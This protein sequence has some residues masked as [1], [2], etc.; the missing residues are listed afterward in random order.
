[1]KGLIV[2]PPVHDFAMPYLAGPLLKGYIEKIDADVRVTCVDLNIEFFKSA[3]EDYPSLLAR[4]R[5][6]LES[7]SLSEAVSAAILYQNQALDELEK[8]S[9]KHQG[10]AWSLRNYK[11][12]LDR[13]VFSE[14]IEYSRSSTPFDELFLTF[15]GQ[16]PTPDFFAVSLTVED[17][18]LPTFR[19]LRLARENWHEI[20]IILGGNLVNRI[21]RFMDHHELSEICDFAVLREGEEPLLYLLRWIRGKGSS[22]EIDP[23]IIDLRSSRIPAMGDLNSIPESLHTKLDPDFQPDFSDLDVHGYLAPMPILPILMSR[24][25]YWGRCSFCT[26]HSAWDPTHRRRRPD[27]ILKELEDSSNKHN[28]KYFRVVD[29]SCPPDL[30]S[31]VSEL[32]HLNSLDIVFEIYGIL[33]K[34]FL[35]EETVKGIATGG[36]RQVFWGLES[37]DPKTIRDMSKGIVRLHDV[38]KILAS[39]ASH[40][41]HNYTFTMFG[42]PGQDSKAQDETIEYVVSD[43]NIHTAV[44]SNFAAELEAPYTVK[45]ADIYVHSG[46]MT[47]KYSEYY[48]DGQRFSALDVGVEDAERA[49]REIYTRRPDLTIT[50][51]LKEEIRL[52]LSDRFGPDFAQQYVTIDP[53]FTYD[54]N[55]ILRIASDERIRRRLT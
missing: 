41:I 16:Y 49:L 48:F 22:P 5:G 33:E 55:K 51:L 15:F 28:V 3:I 27:A 19:L 13:Q 7:P 20:P 10:H 44:V 6:A 12:P 18:I 14:C 42:F 24:K 53:D 32:I 52:V 43:K 37:T 35:N 54:V 2:F 26:I 11:A 17:Q 47:E 23:R 8:C 31:K 1:M 25:C 45:N 34:R 30:L 36:C 40:G 29:E 50:A 38:G 39:S 9:K 21:G 46:Q 4:Y